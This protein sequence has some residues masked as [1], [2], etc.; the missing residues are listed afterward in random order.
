M[1][2]TIKDV[3]RL[4]GVSMSTVS[5]VLNSP[6]SV[7]ENKRKK[8]QKVIDEL[9]YHPNALAR[10]L[11]FKRTESFGVLI[12]DISNMYVSEIMRGME[13]TARELGINL[14]LCNTD[15]NKERVIEYLKVL[16]EKQ[17]DGIIFTSAPI[18]EDYRQMFNQIHLPVVLAS[19]QSRE[20]NIPSVKID[21]E[22]AA[23][24]AALYLLNKGHTEI[25]MIS[26]PTTDIIAGFPRYIGFRQALKENNIDLVDDRIE[27]GSY[28]YEGGYSGMEKLYE[29]SP[30]IT[31]VF[32][33]SDEMALGAISFLHSRGIKVPDNI[34][35]LGFDNTKIARMSIPKLTT[36]AQPM[37]DIGKEAV[38]KLE[39]VLKS[40]KLKEVRTH[41]EH[42]IVERESVKSLYD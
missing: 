15:R 17:V 9:G 40:K 32:C 14:I 31:A 2:P 39:S 18:T 24:D 35:I 21:D 1:K 25:G 16:K 23:Y 34:S 12:P 26:G 11:I 13:D 10:G 19:T 8:V 29:R 33:S 3:A 28:Q 27:F 4:S 41:L 22:K 36:V 7:S 5:R 20:Y 30:H 37:Y 42:T 38:K 6:D